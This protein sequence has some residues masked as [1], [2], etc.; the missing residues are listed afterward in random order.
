MYI[1]EEKS[2]VVITMPKIVV[3]RVFAGEIIQKA[4][5]FMTNIQNNLIDING[6]KQIIFDDKWCD[7]EF[8][9]TVRIANYTDVLDAH[10]D[11]CQYDKYIQLESQ[12]KYPDKQELLNIWKPNT[13]QEE[14]SE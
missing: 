6:S 8:I 14:A 3:Q 13:V 2:I 10:P 4:N 5:T 12:E 11:V 9:P 1:E 7:G